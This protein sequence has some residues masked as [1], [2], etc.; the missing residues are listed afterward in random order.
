MLLNIFQ[1]C[2]QPLRQRDALSRVTAAV[3]L[4]LTLVH[5]QQLYSQLVYCYQCTLLGEQEYRVDWPGLIGFMQYDCVLLVIGFCC[6]E[7][8]TLG[9]QY[10]HTH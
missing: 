9:D 10:I 7:F 1:D 5:A 8:N 4:L 3:A 2:I 6:I